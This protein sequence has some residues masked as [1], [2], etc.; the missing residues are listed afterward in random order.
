M[1]WKGPCYL[2]GQKYYETWDEF[3]KKLFLGLG[4]IIAV[5]GMRLVFPLVIVAIG[6]SRVYLG[7]HHPSD[8]VAGFTVGLAWATFCALGIE[9]IRYFRAKKPDVGKQEKDLELGT[10]PLQ[11]AVSGGPDHP[12]PR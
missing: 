5:F 4:I 10:A 8:V 12:A 6:S 2:I 9:A 3:W 7:V 11:D 1:G